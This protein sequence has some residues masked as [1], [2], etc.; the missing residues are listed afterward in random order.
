ME[1]ISSS[2]LTA[3]GC[4]SINIHAFIL[5]KNTVSWGVRE[6]DTRMFTKTSTPDLVGERRNDAAKP[7]LSVNYTQSN[8][9]CS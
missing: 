9:S 3:F 8:W 5:N 4:G 2:L 6:L 7:C 1:V